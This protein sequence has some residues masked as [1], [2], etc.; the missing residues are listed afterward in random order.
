MIGSDS[1][2]LARR[3]EKDSASSVN[4]IYHLEN[5]DISRG[6]YIR[7]EVS[8][9]GDEIEVFFL[10]PNSS[11]QSIGIDSLTESL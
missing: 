3:A 2:A 4:E 9:L 5:N 8:R 1:R 6:Q 11:Q 10:Q 7:R